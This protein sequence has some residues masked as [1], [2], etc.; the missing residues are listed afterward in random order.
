YRQVRADQPLT[1]GI[2][3]RTNPQ[4]AAL[5]DG[6]MVPQAFAYA[7]GRTNLSAPKGVTATREIDGLRYGAGPH[8]RSTVDLRGVGATFDGSYYVQSVTHSIRKGQYTQRFSL[9]RSGVYPLSPVV[10]P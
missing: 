10:R 3:P 5:P 7:Q 9:K 1:G 4:E 8:A 6:L 2:R